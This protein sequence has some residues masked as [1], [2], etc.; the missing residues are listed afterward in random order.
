[1]GFPFGQIF[2]ILAKTSPL[3]RFKA[4]KRGVK[5]RLEAKLSCMPLYR[6][7]FSPS[8]GDPSPNGEGLS[9]IEADNPSDAVARLRREGRLP[10]NWQSLWVHFLVWADQE[11]RQRGFESIPMSKFASPDPPA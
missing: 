4:I 6:Y 1:L 8:P 7:Y 2:A 5:E 11:G 3:W 10:P 9:S